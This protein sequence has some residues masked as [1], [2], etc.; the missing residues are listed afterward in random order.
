MRSMLVLTLAVATCLL[1]A[2]PAR[3]DYNTVWDNGPSSNRVDMVFLGDGYTASQLNTLYPQ[4][5][6]A[7]LD[8]MFVDEDPFNRYRNFFNVYRV[9]VASNQSGADVPPDGVFR[10]T[11]LGGTYFLDG[12]TDRLLG[13]NESLADAAVTANL[14]GSGI[15]PEMRLVT[16][17]DTRYGGSGG[18]YAVYAGGN[19][20]ATEVAL[21]ELGHSFGG[22]ADQYGGFTT[23]YVGPEPSQP[24]ITTDPTGQKWSQ[25]LGYDQPGIG[26]IGAYEGGG[27]YE[28]GIFRP[29]ENSKM[30]SLGQPFDAVG[31]E[32]LILSI[33][34]HVR[35][36]DAYLA[37][38]SVL[39]SATPLWVDAVDTDVIKLHWYVDG[40]LIPGATGE[41]FDPAGFAL[42]S[43][44]H[45]I[46]L[47]AEDETDW[48]R[49]D[50]EKLRQ[51]VTWTVNVVPEPST[52][53]LA[54]MGAAA[55]FFTAARRRR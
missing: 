21:H 10:D 30:R 13:V 23:P 9:N 6:D 55:L 43:G 47:V 39:D 1:A 36:L 53:A 32:Q 27:Y 38:G 24:D 45:Q 15:T 29:S 11:A 35:P 41:T 31:R 54:A 19:S 12:V 3:A 5:I 8:H 51:E 34:D 7:M 4:H 20:D 42:T 17:N 46:R 40:N 37:T 44:Q 33:Y 14:A 2:A 50:L 52:F 26:V 16:V 25:W 18:K 28:E 48:V 22:L 49:I